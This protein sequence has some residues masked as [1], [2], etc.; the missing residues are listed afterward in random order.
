MYGTLSQTYGNLVKCMELLVK[1]MEHLVK[2]MELIVKLMDHLPSLCSSYVDR[3]K[4][5]RIVDN[6][7]NNIYIV[8][9]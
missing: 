9:L 8:Y 1:L 6:T 7:V 2:C 4:F 3:V 5:H